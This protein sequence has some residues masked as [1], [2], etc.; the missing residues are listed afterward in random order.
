MI[1]R[2]SSRALL[3]FA[4]AAF[5][6]LV[7]TATAGDTVRYRLPAAGMSI[8]IPATWSQLDAKTAKSA[9]AQGLAKE[10]PQLAAVLQELDN[11]G[12]GLAFFAF[13]PVG[14]KRF[15]TNVNI[16]TATI[17]AGVTLQQYYAAAAAELKRIPGRVGGT[18][19]KLVR[20]PGGTAVQSTVD[21]GLTAQ[22]TRIVARVSQWAFFRPGKSVVVSFTTR[23]STAKAYRARF[24]QS[25]R[26]VRFG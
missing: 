12:T 20:L 8:A 13:D 25:A 19:S 23:A 7:G 1:S 18:P 2:M 16:V 6:L 5:A 17:P 24:A 22:G 10:N 3:T 14:A 26:S 4:L 21:I 9:A 11:P 15:A